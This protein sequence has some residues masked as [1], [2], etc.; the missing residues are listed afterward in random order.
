MQG[1][2][3]PEGALGSFRRRMACR[4][5]QAGSEEGST[6]CI[7]VGLEGASSLIAVVGRASVGWAV[8]R[9]GIGSWQSAIHSAVR[10]SIYDAW[11]SL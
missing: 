6:C 3:V 4:G 1:E 5:L 9:V 7:L 11:P 10:P 2:E 8:S